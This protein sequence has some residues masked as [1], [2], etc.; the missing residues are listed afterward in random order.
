MKKRKRKEKMKKKRK[1]EKDQKRK[2]LEKKE[3]EKEKKK[4]KKEHHHPL[5]L[6]AF[7]LLIECLGSG[8]FR[9]C[10]DVQPFISRAEKGD[11]KFIVLLWEC[12]I[13]FPSQIA[14]VDRKG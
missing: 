13:F 6:L 5:I 7:L 11:K 1:K 14:S 4:R 10:T 3:K 9:Q 8:P 12:F 2:R